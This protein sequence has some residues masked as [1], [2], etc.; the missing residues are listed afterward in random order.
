[1][2]AT[3][4]RHLGNPVTASV[5]LGCRAARSIANPGLLLYYYGDIKKTPAR[6]P[7]SCSRRA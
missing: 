6:E 4:A 2:R 7:R 5:G 1:M 3:A